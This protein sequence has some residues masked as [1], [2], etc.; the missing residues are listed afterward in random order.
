MLGQ[1]PDLS[2][3]DKDIQRIEGIISSMTSFER[4]N[5]EKIDISRRRRISRG[6]GVD[7]AEVNRL[8]K[9]HD[10]ATGFLDQPTFGSKPGMNVDLAPRLPSQ[11]GPYKILRRLGE[12]GFGSVYLVAS[13]EQDPREVLFADEATPTP[14][15]PSCHS[16][17]CGFYWTEG[18]RG[19]GWAVDAVPTLK[20][21]SGVGVASPPAIL[22][23]DGRIVTPSIHDAERLQGFPVKWTHPAE[24]VAKRGVRWKLVGNAVSVPVARWLGDRLAS[25]GDVILRHVRALD[26]GEQ[27]PVAGFNVGK[28][29]FANTLSTWPKA[30]PRK[31]LHEFLGQNP[32]PLSRRATAGFL[33]RT[34]R[35]KLRFPPGFIKAVEM[36]LR[37]MEARG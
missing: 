5:P 37:R 21:G 1:L 29:R 22:L 31:A 4:A 9:S 25:P 19:L 10:R 6:C 32:E 18:I 23:P 17:A 35:A 3:A 34:C 12:G 26:R 14:D 15:P 28:G 16:L 24:M 8:L 36:H 20:G 2:G 27:W 13:R 7:A 33:G 11:I 30:V